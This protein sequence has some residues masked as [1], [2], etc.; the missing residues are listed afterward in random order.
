MR[1][2]AR[3][4]QDQAMTA[5]T[6]D[7]VVDALITAELVDPAVREDSIGVVA[8]VLRAAGPSAGPSAPPSVDR[9]GRS[10]P[11]L[12]EVVAYL[13]G[14]LVLA[15]GGLF[16]AQQWD[17]LGFGAQVT[18]LGVVAMVLAVAGV[19]ASRAPTGGPG[20]RAETQDSRRRLAG[21]LMTGAA[22]SVAFLVGYVVDRQLGS[23]QH[24]VY[25]PAVLGATVGAL[26]ATVAY[27]IAPT[28]V[29]LV[30]ILGGLLT[31]VVNVVSWV[32][33][34]DGIVVGGALF[35]I[36]VVWL[37]LAES[38]VFREVTVA[39]ALGVVTTLSGAQFPVVEGSHA[40]HG[41][42]LTA[43]VA[44]VGVVV[45]LGKV[46]WPYLAGAV[47]AVTLV[48]PEAVSDWTDDSLG[49]IGA[50][51]VTGVTLLLASFAGYR[52]RAQA[53]D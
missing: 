53:I 42:L 51:L 39:R 7:H 20:L 4:G 21:T 13:G 23:G 1:A 3:V 44:V 36:G 14:A 6:A 24:D 2:R 19:V 37:V 11:R 30:G 43:V 8:G 10:L 25:W 9:T 16:L 49:A 5:P 35:L 32:G 48:V 17:G 28:A 52:V 29:G 50:V 41:Y 40:W 33:D 34:H 15:A 22:L 38:G 12:V 47:V 45:Y 27:R 31:A 46:T 18:M 26:A